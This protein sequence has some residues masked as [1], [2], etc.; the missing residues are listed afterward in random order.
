MTNGTDYQ[1]QQMIQMMQQMPQYD[2]ENAYDDIAVQVDFVMSNHPN[3]RKARSSNIK[4]AVKLLRPTRRSI[5]SPR[6]WWFGGRYLYT[7]PFQCVVDGCS[8]MNADYGDLFDQYFRDPVTMRPSPFRPWTGVLPG[9]GRQMQGT[10]CP[11]HLMLYHKLVE[12]L[13]Q[14]D[15]DASPGLLAKLSK[16]G[17][18]FVPVKRHA[19]DPKAHPLLVKWTPVF[20]EAQKDGIGIQHYRNPQTGENDL[21]TL[22]FDNRVLQATAPTGT[23]LRNMD[24]SKYYEVLEQMEQSQ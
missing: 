11:Q 8:C 12:W 7:K 16:R 24:M 21:T 9:S 15:Q 1:T 13:E 22:T 18:A 3:P 5:I 19:S 20:L 23:V 14:E 17:V 2:G 10:F 4:Q 6:R